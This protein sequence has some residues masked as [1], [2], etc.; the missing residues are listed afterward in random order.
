MSETIF[1]LKHPHVWRASEGLNDAKHRVC[2][3]FKSLDELL[4]GGLPA[5]GLIRLRALPGI[6]ELTFLKHVLAENPYEKLTMLINAPGHLHAAWLVNNKIKP[7]TVRLVNPENHEDTLWAAEQC[8]KSEACHCVILWLNSLNAK[9]ARRLQVAASQ[10]HTLCVLLE[11][12]KVRRESLPLALDLTLSPSLHGLQIEIN[13][14]VGGRGTGATEI[15]FRYTPDNAVINLA[16]RSNH[17]DNNP[18]QVVG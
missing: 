4:G 18:T 2:T 9:Q 12:V 8:L 13:K 15:Y 14:H 11:S 6:G 5:A 1:P 3:G 10:H 17:G 7:A 16:L